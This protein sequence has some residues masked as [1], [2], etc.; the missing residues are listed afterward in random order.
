MP[1]AA[2][3][4]DGE[5]RYLTFPVGDRLYALPAEAISEVIR[6]PALARVPQ[7]TPSLLGLAN[8]RGQVAP[9]ASIRALIGGEPGPDVRAAFALV[10]SGAAPVA[11]AVDA[12]PTLTAVAQ[13]QTEESAIMAR[14][15]EKLLGVFDARDGQIAHVLDIQTLLAAAFAPRARGKT[16]ERLRAAG[17]GETLRNDV[18]E[19]GK[20]L[21]FMVGGQEFALEIDAVCEIVPAPDVIAATPH[22]EALVL[23]VASYR[24]TLLPL[25]SLRGL[26]GMESAPLDRPKVVVSRVGGAL[27]GLVADQARAIVT[28]EE[29]RADP[30]P[31]VLSA[32]TGAESQI[33]A[34][35]RDQS[36]RRLISIL[37]PDQLFRND[38]MQRMIAEGAASAAAAEDDEGAAQAR[39][40]AFRLGEDE[41]ALPIE[42]VIEVTRV[43]AQI[44]RLPKTPDF[45]EG[46]A[47]F[48]GE[49]LPVIDQRRRFDMPVREADER[50]RAI[51]VSSASHRAALIVDSVSEVLGCAP[52]AVDPAP[53]LTGHRTR[54]VSGVINLE[55][56]GRMVMVLDANELLSRAERSLLD[57]FQ[58]ELP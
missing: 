47:S 19:A 35:Y 12:A 17:P 38:V 23:G 13:V 56:A 36:G 25:L 31:P 41:F 8:L 5:L 44:T 4:R 40:L 24:D 51:V 50:R 49:M 39:F 34:I 54:L 30:P 45:L 6:M 18:Q 52:E 57:A 43:P 15:G 16:H 14:P 37:S 27:V 3:E 1:E 55:S 26:L 46:V 10:M 53:D 22:S 58:P 7:A 32:R 11:L 33:K 9:V 48:R 42:T 29:G 2:A 21:T 28:V 20:I